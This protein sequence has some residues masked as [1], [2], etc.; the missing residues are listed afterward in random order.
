M[1]S[2]AHQADIAELNRRLQSLDLRVRVLEAERS[3]AQQ[4]LWHY[5]GA[6]RDHQRLRSI[7]SPWAFIS[8]KIDLIKSRLNQTFL[9][10]ENL[11]ITLHQAWPSCAAYFSPEALDVPN[12]QGPDW[13]ASETD[14]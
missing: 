11:L 2:Q 10:L 4:A 14:V 7:I 9:R 12:Y 3:G 8:A 13:E 1:Q 6:A 5:H